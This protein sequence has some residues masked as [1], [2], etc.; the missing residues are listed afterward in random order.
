MD[1]TLRWPRHTQPIRFCDPHAIHEPH[2]YCV[3]HFDPIANIKCLRIPAVA[4]IFAFP[5]FGVRHRLCAHLDCN[6]KCSNNFLIKADDFTHLFKH[7]RPCDVEDFERLR[8][9]PGRCF[10][11]E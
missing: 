9:N 1:P 10:V 4:F 6:R 5:R 8:R 2:T 11:Q 7:D 3:S